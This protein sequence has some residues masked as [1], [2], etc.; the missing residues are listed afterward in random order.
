MQ[1]AIQA[2]KLW[3]K[4]PVTLTHSGKSLV[5]KIH[6]L[7]NSISDSYLILEESTSSCCFIPVVPEIICS[8]SVQ[9]MVIR[10]KFSRYDNVILDFNLKELQDL[11]LLVSHFGKSSIL[12]SY[13]DDRFRNENIAFLKKMKPPS[14][15]PK[16]AFYSGDLGGT[17]ALSPVVL[18]DAAKEIWETKIKEQNTQF[19]MKEV[20]LRFSFLTWN[21]ASR[22]PTVDVVPDMARAFRVPAANADIIIIGLEEIDMSFKSMVTGNSSACDK[23]ADIVQQAE[24]AVNIDYKVVASESMGGV[25]CG[26]LVRKDIYPEVRD[27]HITTIKLGANGMFANKAAV[28]FRWKIGEASLVAICCHLAPH[29]QNWEQRNNQWHEIVERL[30]PNVDYIIFLGDLN[31]RIAVTYE[32][33]KEMIAQGKL[34]ELL[35]KDQLKTTQKTDPIIGKFYEA[36]IKFNPTYKFNKDSEV[37]DTSAKKRVPSYTDR[38]LVKTADTRMRVGL[39][40]LVVIETDA[41]QHYIKGEPFTTDCNSPMQPQEYNYPRQP[42]CICYRMIW[43]CFSDHRPVNAC[44]LFPIPV[45]VQERLDE[46][47][48]ITTAKY[49]EMKTL[50]VPTAV[51]VPSTVASGTQFD[52]VNRCIVWVQWKVKSLPPGVTLTPSEGIIMASEK[53]A[54][55]VQCAS[56]LPE[57][58]EAQI[59]IKGGE[60]VTLTIH[61]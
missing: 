44:Y 26:A 16:I 38:I 6:L 53:T 27:C 3:F 20:P 9:E 40:D 57:P 49:D 15:V 41:A 28:L 24:K 29:D 10:M 58:G 60:L 47:G 54:V 17:T 2:T 33:C 56:D 59:E 45:I 34:A 30:G 11:E 36:P 4:C 39:E 42:H 32:Q 23:W 7:N 1:A 13:A 61:S 12:L 14:E 52:L 5:L 51:A 35:E 55:S 50:S 46:L 25:Y 19:Y 8:F 21:V 37:Y 22:E 18:N 31:Y 43:N 48:D